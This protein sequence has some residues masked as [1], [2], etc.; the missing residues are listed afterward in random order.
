MKNLGLDARYALRRLRR[1][2]GFTIFAILTLALGIGATTAVYSA[3]YSIVL[4]PHGIRDVDE[5]VNI[6]HKKPPGSGPMLWLSWPDY[7]DLQKQQTQF[8]HITAWA[9]FRNAVIGPGPAERIVGEMVGGEYF[10]VLRVRTQMGRP[11]QPADDRPDA[12]AVVVISHSFWQRWFGGDPSVIGRRLRIG[13]ELFEI[14]GVTEAGFRGVNLPSLLPTPMWI[15]LSAGLRLDPSMTRRMADREA[16]SYSVK[17]RLKPGHSLRDARGEVSM[18]ANKLDAAAPIGQG[19]DKR[20]PIHSRSRPWFVMPAGDIYLNEQA[21]IVVVPLAIAVIAAVGLV[22][23]VACTNLTNLVLAH[24]SGRRQEIAVR[25][26][27]GA[28][29]GRLIQEQLVEGCLIASA[30]AFLSLLVSRIL[31][32]VLSAPVHLAP[33]LVAQLSPEY[34]GSVIAVVIASTVL[35]ILMVSLL[36][37]LRSTRRVD[38]AL[39]T[40]AA[41][42]AP[43]WRGRRS[44]I[45]AQVMVSAIL[46]MLAA[47]CIQQIQLMARQDFGVDLDRFAGVQVDLKLSRYDEARSRLFSD[48]VLEEVQKQVGVESVAL[49]SAVPLGQSRN[50]YLGTDAMPIVGERFMGVAYGITGT[51][52]MFKVF[53][54]DFIRG[55]VF[56][57]RDAAGAPPVAIVSERAAQ[58]LFGSSDVLGRQ[59]QV[60]SQRSVEDVAEPLIRSLTI[61]GVVADPNSLA[62][63]RRDNGYVFT[64]WQQD[65]NRSI[66]VLAR[67]A[68]DPAA[69]LQPLKSAVQKIDPNAVIFDAGTGAVLAN[70]TNLTPKIMGSIAG[71]LGGFALVLSLV[72]LYGVLSQLVAGRIR[73]I[74]VRLALGADRR[75]ITMM[76]LWDGLYPVISG[77]V[78]GIAIGIG[79]RMLMQPLVAQFFPALDPVILLIVPIAFLTA[80]FFACYLPARRAAGVDPLDALRDL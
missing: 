7:Q 50:L 33:G 67:T 36:P 30:G 39:K 80:A 56:D 31:M 10:E 78:A 55:R 2:P 35:T 73:E 11:L 58:R 49:A 76:I 20:Y 41:T 13:D 28:S 66:T 51:P 25:L 37:A 53:G 68:G 17:A 72:G 48:Q 1:N 43:R 21:D 63:G 38:A 22:L 32:I 75:R 47:L 44:L 60:K 74:G 65:Y 79:F 16:R 64:P 9:T 23:L 15:P 5:V 18:I 59:F 19:L 26:A 45:S 29:R 57:A 12:P 6:Y 24:A 40:N 14:V 27:L 46:I 77:L 34:N 62:L 42:T 52:E 70:A 3:V 71:L 4:R 54:I 69:M 61:I 8:S